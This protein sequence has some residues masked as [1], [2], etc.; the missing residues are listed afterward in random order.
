MKPTDDPADIVPDADFTQPYEVVTKAQ[1]LPETL[2]DLLADDHDKI[3]TLSLDDLASRYHQARAYANRERARFDREISRLG[4]AMRQVKSEKENT[5]VLFNM[6]HNEWNRRRTSEPITWQAVSKVMN[7]AGFVRKARYS[8]EQK[9]GDTYLTT[10]TGDTVVSVSV[11]TM[12]LL[13]KA[14][15]ALEAAGYA[16]LR[17]R[18]PAVSELT[19]KP[20]L[21]VVKLK[22]GQ[23]LAD[24]QQRW[25]PP[26]PDDAGQV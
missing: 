1:R 5:S 8:W 17:T 25:N 14:K 2:A 9:P 24:L 6:L 23:T 4:E 16:I 19:Y 26:E 15:G 12:P 22:P 7:D 10:K 13:E 18:N 20:T 11:E 21:E 3:S